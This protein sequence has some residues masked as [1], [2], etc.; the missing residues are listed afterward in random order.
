MDRR[1]SL[2]S[3][4]VGSLATGALV[5]GCEAPTETPNEEIAQSTDGVYGRTEE[6]KKRDAAIKAETFF[7]VHEM[8]T[9]AILCDLILPADGDYKAA[10]EADVPEF[11]EFIVKDMPNHQLPIRGGLM[12]LD[13][14]A[15]ES[16]NLNFKSCSESQKKT[17]LDQIAFPEEADPSLSQGVRFFSLVRNLTLTGFY[18]SEIGVKE[19]GYAGNTPNVWDG[20]PEEVLQKHG[21]NYDQRWAD[22]YVDQER[23]MDIAQWDDKGNLTT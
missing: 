11:M 23:R 2:K 18:T 4:L 12:W 15:N 17:L 7:T 19:L 9:V 1:E 16:Y 14:F 20:V 8:E 3:I 22:K 13:N 5:Q 21:L 10:T 6:E